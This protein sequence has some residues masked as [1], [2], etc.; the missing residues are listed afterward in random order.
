MVTAMRMAAFMLAASGDVLAGDVEGGA[1]IDRGAQDGNAEGHVHGGLE[2]EELH[3]DVA[4]V[5]IH[6]DDEIVRAVGGAEEDGVGRDGAFAVDA[7][8][9]AGFDWRE[10]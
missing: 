3:G 4:L 8:G 7:A 2:V 6:G 10:R 5:V 1:V 9:A